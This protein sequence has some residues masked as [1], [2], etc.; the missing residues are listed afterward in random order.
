[1]VSSQ[2]PDSSNQE[3]VVGRVVGTWGINGHVKVK[4]FGSSDGVFIPGSVLTHTDG[5]LIVIY[6]RAK[7]SQN[8]DMLVVKFKSIDNVSKASAL[9]GIELKTSSSILEDLPDWNYYHYELIGL[10]VLSNNGDHI[11]TLE[12]IIE[13]GANDVYVVTS[14]DGDELLFPAI[15]DVIKEVNIE[16]QVLI[17]EPQDII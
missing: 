7:T 16:T 1:M 3:V 10:K 8:N 17:V 13:T 2:K 4:R 6:V 11:G 5:E 12:K 9:T 14:S 15:R